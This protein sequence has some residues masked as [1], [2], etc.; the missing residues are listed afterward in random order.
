M[1]P[2]TAAIIPRQRCQT[3]SQSSIGSVLFNLSSVILL[4][5][6]ET[7]SSVGRKAFAFLSRLVWWLVPKG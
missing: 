5:C 2:Q 4:K 1:F 7:A 3:G 6:W